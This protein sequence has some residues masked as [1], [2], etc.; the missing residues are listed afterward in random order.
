MDRA[1]SRISAH[2]L[3][4]GY[5]GHIVQSGIDVEIGDAEIFAI[6]GGS[7]SG[8]S[9]VLR[10]MIGL[11]PPISGRILFDGLTL[12]DRANEGPPPFGVLF[13][14]GALW[15]SMTVLENVMLPMDLHAY[16]IPAAR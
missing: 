16:S 2:D 11:L 3:A 12:S 14:S 13:Q 5:D 1:A 4:V 9:T 8:K 7:G 6:V 10:T 15:T